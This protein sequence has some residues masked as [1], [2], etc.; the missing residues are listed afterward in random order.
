MRSPSLAVLL[1]SACAASLSCATVG[2][3]APAGPP[4]FAGVKRIALVRA[5]A[6]RGG[7]R[8]KDVL[9]ALAESLAARGYEVSRK[10]LGPSPPAELRGLE[11]LYARVDGL[12][13]SAAPRP[14]YGR[15][16]EPA[17]ADAAEVMRALGVDAVAM[18]HRFDDRLL[19]PP[20][21]APIG[22]SLFPSRPEV[23]GTG[24]PVGALSLVDASGN[25]TWFAW[26]AP[27][28]DLDPSQPVNAAEA[29]DMLLRALGGEPEEG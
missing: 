2:E 6:D 7:A 18:Y 29:I 3:P 26:G 20:P 16:V 11:R 1:A 28:A 23:P 17:G 15:R 24:R 12:V 19:L 9:D 8:P 22:G 14:R 10:E 13:A 21:D 5:R 25:A 27:G 4:P